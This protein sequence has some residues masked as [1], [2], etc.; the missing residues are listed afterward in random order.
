MLT[1]RRAEKVP[2]VLVLAVCAV[3]ARFS[4]HRQISTEP[5]FLRGEAWARPARE[6]ALKRYDEPSITILTVYLI[7]GLHEF[8]TCQGG[9]SWMFCGMA[10]RMAYALQLHREVAYDPLG[11]KE[12]KSSELSPTDREIRRRTMWACFLM[13]RFNSSGT[14]RPS[15]AIESHIK[16]QLPIRESNFQMEISGPTQDL[17]GAV[18][19]PVAAGLGQISDPSANMGVAAYL[20]KVIALWGRVVRYLN[21]G[22]KD[23][24]LHPF[25]HPD[26][27]F[28]E[29]KQQV[30]KF[31][32]D[33]PDRLRYTPE[34]LQSFATEKLG[35]QF[36]YLHISYYQTILFLHKFAIPTAP[37][38][39]LPAD[40]PKD[41]TTQAAR[42]AVDAAAKISSL[43]NE[44]ISHRVVAPFAGYCAFASSTVHVW[45][46]FSSNPQLE[47]TSKRDLSLNVKY[48]T[49]MKKHWGMF[50]HMVENLKSIYRQFADWA[51]QGPTANAGGKPD[52]ASFQ[53]GDWFDKYPHG[54]SGTDYQDPA[55]HEHEESSNAPLSQKSDLQSVEDFFQTNQPPSAQQRKAQRKV[56]HGGSRNSAHSKHPTVPKLK[57]EPMPSYAP[58]AVR[59]QPQQMQNSLSTGNEH[60]QALQ[61]PLAAHNYNLFGQPF[62]QDV[63]EDGTPLFSSAQ[64]FP[65]TE[66]DRHL[67][68]GAYAQDMA[69]TPI[70]Q[71]VPTNFGQQISPRD[72][73][74]EQS[75]LRPPDV[76][77]QAAD[78]PMNS[79]IW[80]QSAAFGLQS[81]GGVPGQE[82]MQSSAWFMPFNLMPPDVNSNDASSTQ[83]GHGLVDVDGTQV[84]DPSRSG[85]H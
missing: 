36:L 32:E 75:H 64:H 56:A 69:S 58:G 74:A 66:L 67:V 77:A 28:T 15:I 9:R 42:T 47:A 18:P 24:D 57:T 50:H 33:L 20:I 43:M 85:G 23:Q 44:A 26:S 25:W 51:F 81:G 14:E 80:D 19:N 38:V 11:R 30:R 12:D 16:V 2:P 62:Y 76:G 68:L 29:L 37:G 31:A 7:L 6:I 52:A 40:L 21:L 1:S 10:M 45:A 35:N 82:G 54:V 22:G 34:A 83:Y 61:Q 3:S 39:K 13:D 72:S 53:Y 46:I 78:V 71:R 55:V 79:L 8:G 17:Q 84:Y 70:A 63:A 60:S 4:S 5:A 49:R 65:V 41:F 59:Q 27:Q 48:L 73:G